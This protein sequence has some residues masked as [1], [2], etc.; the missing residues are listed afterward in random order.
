[1]PRQFLKI[2]EGDERQP[3]SKGSG[4][5]ELARAIASPDNPLTARVMVNR[6][7]NYHFGKGIVSTPSDFGLRCEQPIQV[8][9][10]NWLAREFISKGWSVKHI[11]RLI[12]NSATYQQAS[13]GDPEKF[14]V[15]PDNNLLW[16]FNRR[17]LEFEAIHDSMLAVSGKLDSKVGG[18]AVTLIAD[19][20]AKQGGASVTWGFNPYRRAVYGAVS[21]DKLP[22]L[23][24]TF[25]FANPD[26]TNEKR[27]LT[28]VPT[29]GL[30][31]MNSP[32]VMELASAL[33][34]RDDVSTILDSEARISRI[35]QLAFNREPSPGELRAGLHFIDTYNQPD[36][37][38]GK[39]MNNKQREPSPWTY[40]Y[41][42][43]DAKT[44][45]YD[46]ASMKI[47]PYHTSRVMQGDAEYPDKKNGLG[48]TRLTPQGGHAG[49]GAYALVRRWTSPV[50]G[51]VEIAGSLIHGAEQGNGIRASVYGPGGKIK[52]WISH[53]ETADT[54][55]KMIAV[56]KGAVIDFVVD[57]I[58][59]GYY[60]SFQ[61][62]PVLVAQDG[63]RERLWSSKRDFPS[64]KKSVAGKIQPGEFGPW[65]SY[66]QVLLMSNEFVFIQ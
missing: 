37:K 12:M 5:L 55:L 3:F 48:W 21:R 58:G 7:W 36:S 42:A 60:D 25:D 51:S 43:F 38:N 46:P 10:L 11:H 6:I 54:S 44:G 64:P 56:K 22:S 52:E 32:F 19:A 35:Y 4:R 14:A 13:H 29:Q 50:E 45:I 24:L 49:G 53:N 62:F 30:Y 61:W 47:F 28:T 15:D 16:R 34:E 17:R 59:D 27:N 2:I 40:G 26:E 65:Q 66:A 63:K 9:L 33:I 39:G 41:V 18:P 20:T 1:V 23:L 57:A 31:M 8:E